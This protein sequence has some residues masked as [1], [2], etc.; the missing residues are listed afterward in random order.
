M[1]VQSL[2]SEQGTH[3]IEIKDD[4]R[5]AITAG[6]GHWI[7]IFIKCLIKFWMRPSYHG[8]TKLDTY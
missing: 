4:S 1:T 8:K 3:T 2:S 7:K 6:S 5:Y